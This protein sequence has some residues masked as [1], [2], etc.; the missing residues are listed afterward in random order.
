MPH[1]TPLGAAEL[2]GAAEDAAQ[3]DAA[4]GT[5]TNREVLDTLTD[6]VAVAGHEFTG[7]VQQDSTDVKAES[8]GWFFT[9]QCRIHSDNQAFVAG[10]KYLM[11]CLRMQVCPV[12]PEAEYDL[13]VPFWEA[14]NLSCS[15]QLEIVKVKAHLDF[16]E[17][18]GTARYRAYHNFTAD[19]AAEAAL[20][21]FSPEFLS[22]HNA[23]SEQYFALKE[24]A[25]KLAEFHT[26]CALYNLSPK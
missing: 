15:P 22:L 11:S 26:R 25:T 9:S 4:D 16:E 14:L 13:W 3:L 1:A 17:L 23:V 18:E 6:S 19:E 24:I 12:F 20:Q 5:G 21:L 8:L 2:P 7:A 10:A